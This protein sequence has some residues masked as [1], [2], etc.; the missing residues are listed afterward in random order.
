MFLDEELYQIERKFPDCGDDIEILKEMIDVCLQRSRI[1]LNE[2]RDD[3]YLSPILKR[4]NT[5]WNIAIDRLNMEGNI[6]LS[7]TA[8]YSSYIIRKNLNVFIPSLGN[9]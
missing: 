4:I 6:L 9:C 8:F 7:K 2:V 3:K 5:S 1:E